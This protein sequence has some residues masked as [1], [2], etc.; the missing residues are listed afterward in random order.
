[1]WVAK[2]LEVAAYP[3]LTQA[4]RTALPP[5]VDPTLVLTWN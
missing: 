5:N 1:M 2:Q 4:A 3:R